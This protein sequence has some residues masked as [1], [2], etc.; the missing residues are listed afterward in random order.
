MVMVTLVSVL[1]VVLLTLLVTRVATVILVSTGMSQESARFQARSALSGAGFTTDESE[2][3]VEH[4]VRRR[5]ISTLMVFGSAG[6]VTAIA[7]LALS[8]GDATGGQRLSRLLVLA[9]GLGLLLGLSR[10]HWINRRLTAL[11][12]RVLRSRGVDARDYVTLLDLAGDYTVVEMEVQHGDWVAGRTLAELKLRDEGVFVLGIRHDDGSYIGV[13]RGSHRLA[14]GD[15]LVLYGD[16]DQLEELDD[17]RAGAGDAL[18]VAASGRSRAQQAKRA[19]A[20]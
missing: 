15:T 4:P 2:T 1:V 16:A 10:S 19:A 12:G 9:I 14:P 5:V 6:L 7:S 3:V 13:P 11:I 17:R 8:F 18:H 20:G